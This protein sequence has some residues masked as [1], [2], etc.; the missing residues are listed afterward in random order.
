VTWF[1]DSSNPIFYYNNGV[2]WRAGRTYSPSVLCGKF[3]GSH[4]VC[5]MWFSGGSDANPGLNQ[6]IGYAT[7]AL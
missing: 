5:K 3:G 1:K 7:M 4:K 6:G 2:S